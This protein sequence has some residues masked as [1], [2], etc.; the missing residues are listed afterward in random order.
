[1]KIWRMR[2]S[3]WI[4]KA[5]NTNSKYAL[6]I[7]FPL[8]QCIREL[9]SVTRALLVFSNTYAKL[10]IPEYH[11]TYLILNLQLYVNDSLIKKLILFH[12]T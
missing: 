10:S 8:Q 11:K 4:L 1:M 2:I 3:C 7:A 12:L 9:L 6:L 5:T